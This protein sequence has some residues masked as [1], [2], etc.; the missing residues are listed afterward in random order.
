MQ[1]LSPAAA[2]AYLETSKWSFLY[3]VIGWSQLAGR[4]NVLRVLCPPSSPVRVHAQRVLQ[5]EDELSDEDWRDGD[6]VESEATP[7]PRW[8]TITTKPES[9]GDADEDDY[10]RFLPS[11]N[12]G[13]ARWQFHLYDDDPFPAVPHG[14]C[15]REKLDPYL[16]WVYERTRQSSREPRWKIV[17]LWNDRKFREAAF[18]AIDYYVGHHPYYVWRV[19]NPRR[20]PRRR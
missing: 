10:V 4:L 9:R 18:A 15:K 13:L 11:G 19:E 5:L 3:G 6:S 2:K 20:L 7:K 17:A 16:G 12:T 8:S 14:H 1:Y